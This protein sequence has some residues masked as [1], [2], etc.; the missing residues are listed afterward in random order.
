MGVAG[1]MKNETVVAELAS[2][3]CARV[4]AVGAILVRCCNG[5]YVSTAAMVVTN[6]V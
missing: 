1:E 5:G 3:V 6:L 4:I 2:L